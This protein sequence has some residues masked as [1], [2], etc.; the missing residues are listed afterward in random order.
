MK[1]LI[2]FFA[3]INTA[4]ATTA[5]SLGTVLKGA[6]DGLASANTNSYKNDYYYQDRATGDYYNMNNPGEMLHVDKATGN[7]YSANETCYLDKASNTYYCH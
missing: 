6:G 7:I 2:A 1:I 5:H 4:C 3:L